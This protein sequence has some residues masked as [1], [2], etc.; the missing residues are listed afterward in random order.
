MRG[1]T[2]LMDFGNE[3]ME[4]AVMKLADD[5]EALLKGFPGAKN[6]VVGVPILRRDDILTVHAQ[7]IASHKNGSQ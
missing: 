2:D 7:T 4:E 6:D 5:R 3:T 1:M